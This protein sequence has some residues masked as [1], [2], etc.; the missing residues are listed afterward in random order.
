MEN[1]TVLELLGV[2]VAI[3]GSLAGTIRFLLG[4]I[5]KC[6]TRINHI[7]EEFVHKDNLGPVVKRMDDIVEESRRTNSRLDDL[8]K[9]M[10]SS[11]NKN[12]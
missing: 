11:A 12:E 1:Y 10:M 9:Y 7:K 6:H 2:I 5:D 8:M 4:R 3:G